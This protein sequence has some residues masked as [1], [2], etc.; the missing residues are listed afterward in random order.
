MSESARAARRYPE[1]DHAELTDYF[2]DIERVVAIEQLGV[3]NAGN[4]DC[5]AIAEVLLRA[6]DRQWDSG[7]DAH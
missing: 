1:D 6:I 3:G 7:T 2:K 5:F 4:A